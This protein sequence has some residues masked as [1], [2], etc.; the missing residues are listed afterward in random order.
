M[1]AI[2][3][4]CCHLECGPGTCATWGFWIEPLPDSISYACNRHLGEMLPADAS[5]HHATPTRINI[6]RLIDGYDPTMCSDAEIATARASYDHQAFLADLTSGHSTKCFFANG[7]VPRSLTIELMHETERAIEQHGDRAERIGCG[8]DQ[9]RAFERLFD[10]DTQI[11]YRDASHR[12]CAWNGIPIL[13][14][15]SVPHDMMVWFRQGVAVGV[16]ADLWTEAPAIH[17]DRIEVQADDP[18]RFVFGIMN[19]TTKNILSSPAN[20]GPLT[21]KHISVKLSQPGTVTSVGD[22]QAKPIDIAPALIDGLTPGECRERW[23]ANAAAIESG[24]ATP[25]ALSP[26]QRTEGKRL[27]LTRKAGR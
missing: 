16:I 19:E 27:H 25:Y 9:V 22:P 5:S 6:W 12:G 14:E 8:A 21:T 17:I 2:K 13:L 26:D 20:F 4:F 10:A 24:M 15:P 18:D 23:E 7:G 11:K 1:S 3:L